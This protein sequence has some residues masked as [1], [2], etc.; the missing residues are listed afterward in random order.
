MKREEIAPHLAS[1]FAGFSKGELP[2]KVEIKKGKVREIADLGERLLI[3]TSDRIS[4]F[5]RVLTTIPCKG[6]VLNRLSVYWFGQTRDILDNHLIE[7]RTPRSMLVKKGRVIPIEVVVRGYLTGSA[8]RDYA[9]GKPVSG[10]ELPPGM[11]MNQRFDAPLLTPSTKEEQGEHDRPISTAE[12]AKSGIVDAEIWSEIERAA[13]AL[14][15]R[16]SELLES[17]GLILVDTKYEF[18]LVDGRLMLVDEIHTPDSSRFWFKDTYAELFAAGKDQRKIDKE[19]LRGWLMERGFM[20][21]GEPPA[22][23]DEVRIEV[24]WRYIQA[25]ELITGTIF[26]AKSQN[27]EAERQNLMSLL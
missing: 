21:D 2:E 14:F 18:A 25:Y 7:E 3:V 13:A 8:W 27:A 22:I 6:E 16:G 24:A 26:E 19:Y 17:R 9:A 12:I 15:R 10:I 4:A 23:P 1:T 20:G 11:K 5:D